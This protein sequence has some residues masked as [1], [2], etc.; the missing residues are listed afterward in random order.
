M[1]PALQGEPCIP[2]VGAVY[3]RPICRFLKSR[4]VID[5]PYSETSYFPGP[6]SASVSPRKNFLPSANR[7]FLPTARVEPSFA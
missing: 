5:R 3:D 2:T 7:M 6:L 1:L 4:A